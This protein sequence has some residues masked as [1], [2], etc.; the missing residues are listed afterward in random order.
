MHRR[1]RQHGVVLRPLRGTRVSKPSPS[2]PWALKRPSEHAAIA[3]WPGTTT[4]AARV[5]GRAA[6]SSPLRAAPRRARPPRST[7]PPLQ[8]RPGRPPPSTPQSACTRLPASDSKPI[9][10]SARAKCT[11]SQCERGP[12]TCSQVPSMH[13]TK[14]GMHVRDAES[15]ACASPPKRGPTALAREALRATSAW[16]D[17]RR[18]A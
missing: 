17:G 4:V 18:C 11:R 6:W 1:C 12:V 14:P 5:P 7:L 3:A 15:Q 16:N 13:S 9:P 8:G 10:A 2:C